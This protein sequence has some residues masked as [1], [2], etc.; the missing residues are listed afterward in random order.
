MSEIK[1]DIIIPL[2]YNDKIPIEDEKITQA[3]DAIKDKF[4]VLSIDNST[5][6]GYWMHPHKKVYVN[7]TNRNVWVIC[8]DTE[9]NR[10]KCKS[11][12]TQLEA[13]LKQDEILIYISE[14]RRISD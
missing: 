2:N 11:L 10:Q 4:T 3:Y 5:I 12:K 8:E 13:L 14:V 1:I 6:E 7:D 9:E